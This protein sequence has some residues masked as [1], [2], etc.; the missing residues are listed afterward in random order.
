MSNRSG[1]TYSAPTDADRR[2]VMLG[3]STVDGITPLPLEVDPVTGQL[4]VSGGGGGGGGTQYTELATTSPAT[5]NLTLGRYVTSLPTLT[6]GQLNEPMLDS[7]SR[8]LANI[9]VLPVTTAGQASTLAIGGTAATNQFISAATNPLLVAGSD[10][11]GTPR[12]QNLKVDSSGLAYTNLASFGGNAVVTG[13]GTS[14]VGIPRV[15]VSNDS[16]VT[17]NAGTNLNTSALALDATLTGGTQ[18][19]KLTDGTNI[20]NV[21]KSD[22]TAAGQNSQMV[23]GAY[24]QQTYTITSNSDTT[25]IDVGNY[26]SVS[27]HVTAIGSGAT[28]TWQ[29][30][31]DNSNWF[32]FELDLATSATPG[33]SLNTGVAAVSSYIGPLSG[34]YF[35]LH[36][37]GLASGTYTV[38]VT[39]STVQT[40]RRG[41]SSTQSGTWSVGA[42]SATGSAV[43]ANAFYGGVLAKTTSP[44]AASTG[45][46]VG[47]LADVMGIQL[48]STGGLVTTAFAAGTSANTVIK[49]TAGRLCNIVVT[50]L[51]T[52]ALS[53]YDNASTNSG[54]ILMQIPASAAA[55]TIYQ[56]NMPAA[57]GITVAGVA[58]SPGLTI[59]WI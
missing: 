48:V 32:G 11:G 27:V 46:L 25:A 40:S 17:A 33:G 55:G 39:F 59:S 58:N 53:I 52:A 5:G 9:A 1:T 47:M 57:N 4:Q 6:N 24:L 44:A 35:R 18:Q 12:V 49:A 16:T 54:T 8:L 36:P 45:N 13:T 37:T 21:L 15:T 14:G 22:G 23:S 26:A 51:G 29:A 31:N 10:Y 30:S 50:T 42:S 28:I 56:L 7:S 38:V 43:P 19:A 3:V 41:V 2:P 20:A 34:R